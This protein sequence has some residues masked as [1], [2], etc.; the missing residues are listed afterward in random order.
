MKKNLII[1]L[2]FLFFLAGC[3]SGGGYGYS[4]GAYYRMQN[5]QDN[6]QRNEDAIMR[7]ARLNDLEHDMQNMKRDTFW[8]D[9]QNSQPPMND[10]RDSWNR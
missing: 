2:G 6:F 10:P 8:N 3:E 5:S 7:D 1:I 4:P 9:F